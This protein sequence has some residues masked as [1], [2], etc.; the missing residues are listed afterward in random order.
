V[1]QKDMVNMTN[2]WNRGDEGDALEEE[3]AHQLQIHT[4]HAKDLKTS[5][6]SQHPPGATLG[7]RGS[8]IGVSAALLWP[9]AV[10]HT[11]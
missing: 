3:M 10:L 6:G 1:P 8:S 2:G 5:G 9:I 4:A 11:E 7:T